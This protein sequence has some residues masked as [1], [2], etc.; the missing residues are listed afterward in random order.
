[1]TMRPYV[2][3]NSAMSADGK[4]ATRERKQ[5]KISGENDFHRVE[6]LRAESDAIMV[7]I[8]TVFSDDP[9]LRL[10]KDE[11][12]KL[13]V[14]AGKSEHPMR[15]VVDSLARMP[16]DSD[17]FKKGSG[18]VVIFVSGK[19]P[20]E[21]VKALSAKADVIHAGKDSIDL[22]IVLDKLGEL[23]VKQLM[24]EGG[25][26]LLWSFMS[27]ELFD[28]IRIYIGALII[29]GKN[30]PTFCDGEGFVKPEDFTRLELKNAEKIDEGVLLTWT[31]K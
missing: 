21:K 10:K 23:G 1:M 11:S 22:G 2:I 26:T 18:R 28:E 12:A 31:R 16:L 25:S 19:A 29:G 5:T 4:L 9:S 27:A 6:K 7:G 8:G 30:A 24:V 13:R 3:I 17:M 15:V 14:A 20:E